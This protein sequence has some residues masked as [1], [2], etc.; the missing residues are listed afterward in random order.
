M[1][2]FVSMIVLLVLMFGLYDKFAHGGTKMRALATG[3]GANAQSESGTPA[4]LPLDG[5]TD[6]V[7]N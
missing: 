3:F 6:N 1:I 4:A 5:E 7:L 2:R